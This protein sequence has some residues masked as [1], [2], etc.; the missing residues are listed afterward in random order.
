MFNS[1]VV[2][3]SVRDLEASIEF[4]TEVLGFRVEYRIEDRLVHI[5]GPGMT[6][7]LRPH[8][9]EL[10][11]EVSPHIHIGLTVTDLAEMMATLERRGVTFIGDAIETPIA[12]LAF[13]NDPD[14]NAFYLCQWVDAAEIDGATLQS[15]AGATLSSRATL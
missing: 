4:Y 10:E 7:A 13:F 3:L 15:V 1:A 12:N 8:D 6:I 9:S 11:S 5:G 2:T 14:G